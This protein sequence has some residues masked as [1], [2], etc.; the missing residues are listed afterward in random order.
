MVLQANDL[1]AEIIKPILSEICLPDSRQQ[2]RSQTGPLED[3][4]QRA[5]W[6]NAKRKMMIPSK[7]S[8]LEGRVSGC[9]GKN[10]RSE[11]VLRKE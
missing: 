9:V 8:A 7:S 5:M 6:K 4:P 11:A 2:E 3:L 10:G 1:R